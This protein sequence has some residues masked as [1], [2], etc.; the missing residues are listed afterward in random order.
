M[1]VLSAGAN[2]TPRVDV[3]WNSTFSPRGNSLGVTVIFLLTDSSTACIS[4]HGLVVVPGTARL[5]N[6]LA[7]EADVDPIGVVAPVEPDVLVAPV[8]A[9][10]FDGRVP[11]VPAVAVLPVW[12][13]VP[14]VP[15]L[16][17]VTP[18]VEPIRVVPEISNKQS[19]RMRNAR[20]GRDT[21]QSKVPYKP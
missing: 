5:V 10:P 1:G 7:T 12:P 16:P 4:A 17:V 8:G 13:V 15:V 3:T 2:E 11:V 21:D 9:V 6:V 18:G 14:A 19:F 20:S